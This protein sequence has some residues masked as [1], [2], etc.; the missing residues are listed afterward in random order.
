[1]T[2]AKKALTFG[3]LAALAGG[4]AASAGPALN[5]AGAT[6]PA[7]IYQRWFQDLAAS[8][9]AKVNYQ[10]VGSGAG[11]RQ[12]IAGT[13]DFG[14]T[15]EPIKDAEAAKV[16]RGVIQFPAVGGTIAIAYNKAGCDLKLTQKQ[17]AE[18]F[19]GTT[20]ASSSVA[21]ARSRWRTVPMVPA[22][23]SRSPTPSPAS[24]Q[25]S[26]ARWARARA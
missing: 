24:H 15:D 12:Y 26:R 9:G 2:F 21:R 6:F 14:A 8:G 10:S 17:A 1:M 23:P 25:S 5:G 19:L 13:V 22:P 18:I 3:T 16:K 20:G 7:P 4:A 11:V